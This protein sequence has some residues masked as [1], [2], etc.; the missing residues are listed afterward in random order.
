MEDLVPPRTPFGTDLRTALAWRW[1]ASSGAATV[2]REWAEPEP[3]VEI[4]STATIDQTGQNLSLSGQIIVKSGNDP[5][6]TLP[7][8]ISEPAIDPRNWSF[9]LE[10]DGHELMKNPLSPAARTRFG[11]PQ[12]GTA[13]EL[14]LD[15]FRP[16]QYRVSFKAQAPWKGRG[17]IPIVLAPKQYLPRGRVLVET[18]ERMLSRAEASG[19]RRADLETAARQAAL[20]EPAAFP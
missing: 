13:W 19:L 14:P 11:F 15:S 12:D 2:D 7:V 5:D 18:P 9:Q 6:T 4:E 3:T 20:D 16:G 8:W 10:N 17:A 1:N